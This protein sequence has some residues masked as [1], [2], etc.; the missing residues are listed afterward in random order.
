[1]FKRSFMVT[2]IVFAASGAMGGEQSRCAEPM[3]STSHLLVYG[4]KSRVENRSAFG[5]EGNPMFRVPSWM[6]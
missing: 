5:A 2:V 6:S 4:S 3:G 1:M